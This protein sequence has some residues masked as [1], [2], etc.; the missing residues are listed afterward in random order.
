MVMKIM[1]CL[2]GSTLSES[3][4]PIS[5]SLA[6]AVHAEVE[7]VRVIEHEPVN[8][9]EAYSGNIT[10]P[11]KISKHLEDEDR[12]LL[13]H[14]D[15]IALTFSTPTSTHLLHGADTAKV[16]VEEANTKGVDM[17]V[18]ATHS[19]GSV[20]EAIFGSV[21]QEVTKSGVAPVLMVH[22]VHSPVP[23]RLP[24]GAYVFTSDGQDLGK[25]QEVTAR[26]I[27]VED[28]AGHDLWLESNDVATIEAGRI[29]LHYDASDLPRHV[30][31]TA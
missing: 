28:E 2:D 24:I 25:L 17:V 23:T 21:A 7:I 19:R 9:G 13:E 14:L 20:G 12:R 18:M 22:P 10:L 5:K 30:V 29:L 31:P 3:A 6:E 1:L 11:P 4:I 16:L 15:E 8:T 27:K 26:Q